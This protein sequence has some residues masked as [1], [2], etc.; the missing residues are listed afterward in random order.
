MPTGSEDA[1]N[2]RTLMLTKPLI[3]SDM[4]GAELCIALPFETERAGVK[5]LLTG[6]C[7]WDGIDLV[8]IL[9]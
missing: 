2:G 3:F 1:P 5:Q 6:V 7:R 9:L 4:L 8:E